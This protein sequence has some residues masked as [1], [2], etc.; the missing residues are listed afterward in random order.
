MILSEKA[1][2]FLGCHGG[3]DSIKIEGNYKKCIKIYL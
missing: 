2:V 3:N 1:L